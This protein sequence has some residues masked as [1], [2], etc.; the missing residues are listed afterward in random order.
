MKRITILILS[1]C[2][3]LAA[4][5]ASA[6]SAQGRGVFGVFAKGAYGEERMTAIDEAA[7]I[8]R[9]SLTVANG[10]TFEVDQGY[11]DGEHVFIGYWKNANTDLVVLH[12]GAPEQG[13]EWDQ[14]LEDWVMGEI[15]PFNYPD[16]QK[17]N[18]WLDGK[19]Q[20]WLESPYCGIGDVLILEDG[21]ECS[22]I[23]GT[24]LKLED[25]E[26]IGY[27]E[28][29]IPAE[30]AADTLTVTLPVTSGQAVK[31]QDYTTFRE[32]F[33]RDDEAGVI[34]FTLHRSDR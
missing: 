15:G 10:M 26:I 13:L 14:V 21:T 9:E 2:L 4:F 3:A 20:R 5:A 31:F 25:G 19:G 7:E 30:K 24:E 16:V 32:N 34:T 33:G 18:E 29:V 28:C 17:E 12:E 23:S 1:A 22:F 8:V 6:E 11:Y 27:R